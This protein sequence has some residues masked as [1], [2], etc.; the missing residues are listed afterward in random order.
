MAT[1]VVVLCET[2]DLC[3]HGVPI[4]IKPLLFLQSRGPNL[5]QISAFQR[6][7]TIRHAGTVYNNTGVAA[8]C[9]LMLH[10]LE[11]QCMVKL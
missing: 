1:S 6:L 7:V 10:S 3:C 4:A 5:Y 8:V 9:K 2:G 11:N